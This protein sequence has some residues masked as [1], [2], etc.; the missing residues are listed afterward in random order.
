[1]GSNT[2][3]AVPTV[4]PRYVLR[5][6]PLAARLVLTIFLV[7]VGLGYLAALV[8]LHFQHAEKG[9]LF[10]D[11]DQ[12]YRIFHD[13]R[14][15]NPA[16]EARPV[17]H[18]EKLVAAAPTEKW[19][20]NG[21][22]SAAFTNEKPEFRKA[23]GKLKAAHPDW[24]DQKAEAALREQR[25][26]ERQAVLA[27][28][29]AGAAEEAYAADAFPLPA[30]WKGPPVTPAFAGPDGKSVKVKS[31]LDA[32]CARCHGK[33]GEQEDKPLDTFAAI[34]TYLPPKG[35]EDNPNAAQPAL[36][37]TK[38]AQSTHVHLLSFS[39]LYA[40]TGFILVFTRMPRFLKIV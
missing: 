14:G 29:A 7:S 39:I 11:R 38:L 13:Q 5:D 1:M 40:L 4:P 17:G 19:A 35:A 24:D 37:M 16:A 15:R 6:L 27:W 36:S 20:S 31:I 12:T 30:D 22:M 25:E 3:P 28:L 10:P 8:Q 18:M 32:R 2:P 34:K 26:G 9:Q 21:Q 33:E 23:L